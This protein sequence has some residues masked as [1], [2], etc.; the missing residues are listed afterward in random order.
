[1]LFKIDNSKTKETDSNV[2]QIL[3]SL[4][5]DFNVILINILFTVYNEISK[6]HY[7]L[8]LKGRWFVFAGKYVK[9]DS[10]FSS[11]TYC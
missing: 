3:I 11:V 1:M 7:K 2:T 5:T 9:Y 8:S 6:Y 4:L 10:Y